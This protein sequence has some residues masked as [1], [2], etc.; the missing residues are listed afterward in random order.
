MRLRVAS[1]NVQSFR[2]G[3]DAAVRVLQPLAVNLALLQECGPKRGLARFARALDMEFVS[4]HRLLGRVHNA[5]LYRAPWR[6]TGADA[7][8]L[9]RQ[10]RASPR[11]F[12][13]AHLRG[14]GIQLLAVSCHLGL[15]AKE[16]V[17][18]AREVTDSLAGTDERLVLG[19]DVNEG[20]DGPAARWIS[21]RLFDAHA[22][23][24]EGPG[25]TFPA[26]S[27]TIRIDFVFISGGI[28]VERAWIPS[29]DAVARAADHR[30]VVADVEV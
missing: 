4:S 16:R 25:E 3:V 1:W 6:V 30:P 5:V 28:R 24:G 21:E 17:I 15:V 12:V 11:G 20:P 26:R 10:G 13:A 14:E 9:T 22:A 29:G 19:I 7:S 2:G 8:E 23:A 18:H 27:P